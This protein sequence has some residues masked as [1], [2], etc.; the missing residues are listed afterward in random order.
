MSSEYEEN[1]LEHFGVRGM[2]WGQRKVRGAEGR[3]QKLE[4][5]AERRPTRGN[6]RTAQK[7]R[8][9][10]NRKTRKQD[11]KFERKAQSLQTTIKLHNRAAELSNKVDVPRINNKPQYKNKDFSRDTP[12][13]QKYYKEHQTAFLNNLDKAAKEMGTNA[14]GTKRYGIVEG[15]GSWSVVLKDVKHANDDNVEFTVKIRYDSMGHITFIEFPEVIAQTSAL[16]SDFLEHFGVR[17]MRWGTR[18][19]NNQANRAQNLASNRPTK[20]NVKKA[21]KKQ[22]KADWKNRPKTTGL[23]K[24][25]VAVTA[26]GAAFVAAHFV[27]KKTLNPALIVVSGG[28]AAIA[29][30]KVS[31]NLIAKHRNT[32]IKDI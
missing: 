25:A 9:V 31:Q 20:H 18:K 10:A 5:Q 3:T 32:P 7:A 28:A 22:R 26:V 4:R 24:S 13:R 15:D 6:V 16:D 23:Q 14:S 8:A 27:G 11:K 30:K 1:V 12:L 19:A 2:K 17:G 29:G 21:Q